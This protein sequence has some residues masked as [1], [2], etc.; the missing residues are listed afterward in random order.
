MIKCLQ[1]DCDR[2]FASDRGLQAH[3]RAHNRNKV[4]APPLDESEDEKKRKV[5]Q[6]RGAAAAAQPSVATK[7]ALLDAKVDELKASMALILSQVNNLCAALAG[8]GDTDGDEGAVGALADP[9]VSEISA[10][11]PTNLISGRL[12]ALTY[13]DE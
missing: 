1:A 5:P 6:R 12:A 11:S 9:Q 10:V 7:I 8:G 13:D 3:M 2:V 4:A